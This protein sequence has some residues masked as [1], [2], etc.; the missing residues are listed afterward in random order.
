LHFEE[1]KKEV[2]VRGEVQA[3]NLQRLL[4]KKERLS[5]L[6]GSTSGKKPKKNPPKEGPPSG[7]FW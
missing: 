7:G 4:E 3:M 5:K 6:F 1:G 2:K